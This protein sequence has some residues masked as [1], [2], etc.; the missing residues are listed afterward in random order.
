MLKC[1]KYCQKNKMI[2]YIWINNKFMKAQIILLF[3]LASLISTKGFATGN[4]PKQEEKKTSKS[5]YDFNLFKFF[6]IGSTQENSDSLKINPIALP[7][8]RKKD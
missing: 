3:L 7:L 5:K 2:Y 8:K 6:S 4:E 1:V